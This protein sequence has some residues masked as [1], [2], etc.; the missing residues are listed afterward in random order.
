[1]IDF[2]LGLA[3]AGMLIRGW[4]RGFVRETLDLIGLVLGLLLA[5]NLSAPFADFLTDSFGVSPEVARIGGGIVLF[6]LFGVLLSVAASYLSKVMDLPG[7]SMVN[8]VGG[9]AVA[10]GWG[11]VIVLVVVGLISALPL[12]AGWRD[13]IESSRVVHLIAGEE[14]APRQVFESVAGDNVM[15]ATASLR[16]LFGA[17]RAVPQG[18][19]VMEIPPA[20]S[21]EIRQVRAE[22]EAVLERL[23]EDR[24]GAGLG[25]VQVTAALTSLA[26]DYAAAQYTS[27]RLQRLQNCRATLAS[28][29]Y[30]V[31]HCDNGVALAATAVGAYEG[32]YTSPSGRSMADNALYDRAGASVVEGPTGRLVVIILGG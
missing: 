5:F 8:R 2:V 16:Q 17:P 21:D 14:A 28:R 19:Q 30:Q 18:D 15:T 26:E 10:M 4:T 9:A 12:P 23:N 13:Q 20:P 6:V 29:S 31:L 7:L 24:V 32:I 3:L 1:M 25:A 27:G 22:A 11:I